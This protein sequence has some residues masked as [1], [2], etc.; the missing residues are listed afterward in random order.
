MPTLNSP[1]KD[2]KR[3]SCMPW[4]LAVLALS[5]SQRV[6]R[7]DEPDPAVLADEQTLKASKIG[8]DGP[9]LVA[10][11][12]ERTLGKSEQQKLA[13][14]VEQL[15]SPQHRVREE[16][17]AKLM[18][19]GQVAR[20]F[21]DKNLR[22]KDEEIV[23]RCT[24]LLRHLDQ[25]PDSS[26]AAAAARLLG[27]VRPAGAAEALL[28]YLPF[29]PD[30]YVA[31]EI[32]NALP[33]VA[34]RNGEP[35]AVV[36]AALKDKDAGKRGAAAQALMRAKVKEQVPA[37][38][39]LLKDPDAHVRFR[40]ALGLAAIRERESVPA[41][42]DVLGELPAED[43][44][45]AQDL[46]I[47]LA[48]E[49]APAVS[50]GSDEPSRKKAR[51]EWLA[52][53][54]R[55]KGVVDMAILDKTQ[56]NLGYT[57]IVQQTQRMVKGRFN[58]WG[59]VVFELDANKKQRWHIDF[60]GNN[61][62]PVDAQVLPGDKVLITEYQGRR[63]S[64]RDFKGNIL[65][66]QT[67]NGNPMSA[68][69]QSSGNTFV[70]TRNRLIEIDRGGK[71]VWVMQR[72]QYDILRGFKVKNGDVVFITNN[73][74][75]SRIDSRTQ[76]VLKSFAVGQVSYLFGSIDVL[77]SG[78]VLVPQ[79]NN[80]RVVEF[81]G[82]GREVWQAK[83]HWPNSVMR[84]PNGNTLVSSMNMRRVA[85]VDR[86][87]REVWVFAAEGQGQLLQARRR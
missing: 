7:A 23:R 45:P 39:A 70:V 24:M 77:P 62:Y 25:N 18:K 52:W 81:D 72:P 48:G 19:A 78:N 85:E 73:G 56:P 15:G 60:D 46:L 74:S 43:L 50:L 27:R 59:G 14:L 42:I 13:A 30:A 37:V 31:E 16:A 68:Q 57:V 11:F 5:A 17:T 55:Y 64:E 86:A 47:R 82:N 66:Q 12:K 28:A 51:D 32:R 49:Q 53:W 63:V 4:V 35:E 20:P 34:V 69:R 1:G 83:V 8:T 3:K 38:R 54:N 26:Q 9:A 21:L 87:G 6:V 76:K 79:F 33:A 36:V 44:W 80:Q 71:E 22:H 75:L 58:R 29:A 2:G 61:T 10:F 65:W 84:L 40:A 67:V 41:L